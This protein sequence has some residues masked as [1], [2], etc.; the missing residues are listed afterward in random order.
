MEYFFFFIMPTRIDSPHYMEIKN[1]CKKDKLIILF[2]VHR[3]FSKSIILL[4]DVYGGEDFALTLT[5]LSIVVEMNFVSN[6][7]IYQRC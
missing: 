6:P 1:R 5:R 4:I 2:Q 3:E 7:I